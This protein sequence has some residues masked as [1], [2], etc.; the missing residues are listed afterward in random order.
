MVVDDKEGGQSTTRVHVVSGDA[1][2]TRQTQPANQ[3][4]Q[5]R[6]VV[7]PVYLSG[8]APATPTVSQLRQLVAGVNDYLSTTTNGQIGVVEHTVQPWTK[9]DV[10]GT[11]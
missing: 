6:V 1:T 2:V 3:L 10:G 8:S 4:G 11:T 9:I 5:H 7:A